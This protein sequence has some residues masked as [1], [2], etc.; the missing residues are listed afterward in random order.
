MK[1]EKGVREYR[2]ATVSERGGM[3]ER[4]KCVLIKI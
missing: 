3:G 2:G 4:V 1:G